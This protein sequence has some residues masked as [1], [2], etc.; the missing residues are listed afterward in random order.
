[1]PGAFQGIETASRALRSFQTSLNTTGHNIAN[2]NTKGYSRQVADLQATQ[3]LEYFANGIKDI[4]TGVSV[5]QINR[6]R[7]Q[8]LEARRQISY[9]EQGRHEGNLA[10]LEKVQ[11]LFLDPQAKGIS[12]SV[13]KFFNSWS[14]LGSDPSNPGLRQDVQSAGRE[15]SQKIRGTYNDLKTLGVSQDT[16]ITKTISDIQTWS[17]KV[18]TLNT[19]IRKN[20]AQGGSPNDLMDQ[21]DEA[22]AELSKLV[23]IH[24]HPASD[25]T[26]SVFMGSFTLVD[27]IGS[28]PFPTIANPTNSTVSD[29]SL[30][31]AVAGGRLKGLFDSKN[32]TDQYVTQLDTLADTVKTQVN[33]MHTT[34]FTQTGATLQNFFYNDPLGVNVG[35]NYFILDAA[36]D[37]STQNIAVGATTA[38]GDGS[39]AL[40]ISQLRDTNLAAL[41]GTTPSNYYNTMLNGVGN[42]V[43]LAKNNV[44]TAYALSEQVDSQIQEI[45]GVSLDEEMAN[46]M[47]F[48]KSYQ[49]SARVFSIMD[50]TVSDLIGML[51]R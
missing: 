23:D 20:I 33:S 35:A 43:K 14:A 39:I 11:A 46:M 6:I 22:I 25:G 8:F 13:D 32:T 15:L 4:G 1:L 30:T 40:G 26:L 47:K 31:W 44:D 36:I 41:G 2:V 16:Q 19:D 18:G 38:K 3:P 42:A 28:K 7:D 45:A 34:G 12:T 51:R 5:N 10:S 27:Q 9:G 50:E 49:A 48:Q 21:R 37:A 24:T 29:G 17:D